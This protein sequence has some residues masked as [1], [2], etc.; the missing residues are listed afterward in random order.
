[1]IADYGALVKG[2]GFFQNA[3]ITQNG[4]R[5]QAGNSPG[6][7][8]FGWF[9]LG[10]GGVSDYVF[11]INDATGIAGPAPDA[12][13]Q[14][15]GWGLVQAVTQP[16]G[17]MT[18]SGDFDWTADA[19][20]KLTVAI[21]TLLNPT[22]VGTDVVGPMAHFDSS[23]AYSWPAITWA[24]DYSGPAAPAALVAATRFDTTDFLNPVAGAFGWSLDSAGHTL[25]LTYTPVPEP[26][27][28]ALGALAAGGG[29]AVWRRRQRPVTLAP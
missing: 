19:D 13:G 5:F 9:I 12:A 7:A 22:T 20:H 18:T 21:Q 4:G 16:V 28:L 25:S 24:G 15:S 1:V 3:V 14:V 11:A 2:A 26:S 29:L 17:G 27:T 8:K 6:V 10:P 23:Q